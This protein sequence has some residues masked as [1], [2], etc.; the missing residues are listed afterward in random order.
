MKRP[1]VLCMAALLPVAAW[2][3]IVPTGYDISRPL[4]G[5]YTWTYELMLAAQAPS[6]QWDGAQAPV[7]HINAGMGT[8]ITI[9]D[10]AGYIAGSCSGPSGWTC[11]TQNLGFTPDSVLPGDDSRTPNIT[12]TYTSGPTLLGQASGL[13]LGRFSAQTIYKSV[14][15]VSYAVRG[16]KSDGTLTGT[17]FDTVGSTAGPQLALLLIGEPGSLLLTSIALGA[18]G[19]VVLRRSDRARRAAARTPSAAAA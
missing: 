4:D 15:L 7:L 8:F 18:L 5:V 11:T 12:W 17:V 19:L 2:A 6:S 10:F 1:S 14:D 13:D 3:N 9:Y 16:A